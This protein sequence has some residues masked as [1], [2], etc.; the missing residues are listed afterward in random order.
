MDSN[1]GAV[2]VIARSILLAVCQYLEEDCKMLAVN[3]LM[4]NGVRLV[5]NGTAVVVNAL[6]CAIFVESPYHAI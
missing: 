2:E 5:L 3:M 4:H 1:L 6:N